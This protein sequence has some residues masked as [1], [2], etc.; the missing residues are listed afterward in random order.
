MCEP[1]QVYKKCQQPNRDMYNKEEIKLSDHKAGNTNVF[2]TSEMMLILTHGR[3]CK[4]K[5]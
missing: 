4:V 3:K 2:Y 5:L 1:V